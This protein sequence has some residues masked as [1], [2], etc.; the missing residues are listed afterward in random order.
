VVNIFAVLRGIRAAGARP[1]GGHGTP[2]NLF[3]WAAGFSRRPKEKPG[4][5]DSVITESMKR[6]TYYAHPDPLP[7]GRG[8]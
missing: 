7:Q 8:K 5:E 4:Q 3:P 6:L 2:Y 1:N